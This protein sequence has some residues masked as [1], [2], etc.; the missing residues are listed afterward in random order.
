MEMHH[1]VKLISYIHKNFN[2]KEFND[3]EMFL[4]IGVLAEIF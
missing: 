1:D 2:N 3:A 4:L